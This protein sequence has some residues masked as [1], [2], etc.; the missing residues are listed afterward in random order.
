MTAER[1]DEHCC[2]ICE[3]PFR[4]GEMVLQDATEGLGHRACFGDDR[5]GFVDLV[6]GDPLPA[7][8]PLPTGYP[9]EAQS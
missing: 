2:F 8:A 5:E 1:N 7:D 6:T 4:A 3:K 9:Y